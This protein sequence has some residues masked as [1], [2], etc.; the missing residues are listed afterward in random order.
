LKEEVVSS[1][2]RAEE[3]PNFQEVLML[4]FTGGVVCKVFALLK[5]AAFKGRGGPKLSRYV[6]ADFHRG[7]VC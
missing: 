4:I 1:T 5:S 6:D 3:A 7:V 2:L